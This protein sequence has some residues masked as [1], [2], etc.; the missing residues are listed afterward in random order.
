LACETEEQGKRKYANLP[1]PHHQILLLL[2]GSREGVEEDDIATKLGINILLVRTYL[3]SLRRDEMAT[4]GDEPQAT[5]G[6][7][8]DWWILD[9]GV[10][11]LAERGL[12]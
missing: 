6:A 12:L 7:G 4:D 10:E 1:K 3:K 11:Y 9:K 2:G 5:Y 8:Q